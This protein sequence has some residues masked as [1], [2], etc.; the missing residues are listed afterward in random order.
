MSVL[1]AESS[2]SQGLAAF[3]AARHAEAAEH[4]RAAMRIEKQRGVLRPDARFLSYYGLSLAKST[5]PTPVAVKACERAADADPTNPVL[6]LN[7]GRIYLLAGLTPKAL[8]CFER[9]I[10]FAPTHGPL[11]RELRGVERREKP[12]VPGLGRS[13]P[14]NR[15]AGR[16][17]VAVRAGTPRWLSPRRRPAV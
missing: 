11:L 6:L 15:W 2:F 1:S 3:T 8:Q 4:F 14:I 12:L 10:R 9:G 13:H 5:R 16:V 7:L 17:R